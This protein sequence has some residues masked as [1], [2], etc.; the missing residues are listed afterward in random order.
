MNKKKE[1]KHTTKLQVGFRINTDRHLHA[2]VT[3]HLY[4][5]DRCVGGGGDSRLNAMLL[6]SNI[7]FKIYTPEFTNMTI[8]GK[9]PCFNRKYVFI[10]GGLFNCHVSFFGDTCL[11]S[12]SF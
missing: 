6:A 12:E 8:P 2:I 5:A 1:T 9:S 11:F 4:M 10:H 3:Q 7:T